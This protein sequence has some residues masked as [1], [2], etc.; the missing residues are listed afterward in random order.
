M[1]SA[2]PFTRDVIDAQKEA[3]M[4]S[5]TSRARLLACMICLAHDRS[6]QWT[7]KQNDDVR[8][9]GLGHVCVYMLQKHTSLVLLEFALKRLQ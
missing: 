9:P 7:A 2:S 5:A 4:T 8:E 1:R 6:L 3:I